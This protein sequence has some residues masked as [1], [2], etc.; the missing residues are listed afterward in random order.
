MVA[1]VRARRSLAGVVSR[2]TSACVTVTPA[3]VAPA[4]ARC[5]SRAMVSVSGSSG[6]AL[7]LP[8]RDV[9]AVLAARELDRTRRADARALGGGER[10]GHTGHREHASARRD[11]TAI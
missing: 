1:P 7:E 9:G 5:R 6:M 8:P 4:S 11:E 10:I 2:R 3:I